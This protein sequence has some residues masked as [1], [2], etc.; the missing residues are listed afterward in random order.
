MESHIGIGMSNETDKDPR[1]VLD[2]IINN[3]L[4]DFKKIL[5]M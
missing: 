4:P 2:L 5:L 3:K 1:K